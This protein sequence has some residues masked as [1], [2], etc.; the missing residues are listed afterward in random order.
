[1]ISCLVGLIYIILSLMILTMILFLMIK[2][3]LV[4]DIFNNVVLTQRDNINKLNYE[5]Y[6]NNKKLRLISNGLL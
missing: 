3:E 2:V 4:F 6:L 5:K 1:M